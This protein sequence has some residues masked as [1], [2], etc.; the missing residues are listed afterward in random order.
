MLDDHCSAEWASEAGHT[1]LAVQLEERGGVVVWCNTR[2]RPAPDSTVF[3]DASA[4][5]SK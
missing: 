5:V 4:T 3:I 2:Q 1:E